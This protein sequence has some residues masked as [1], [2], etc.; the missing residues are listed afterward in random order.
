M[1]FDEM[2]SAPRTAGP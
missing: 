2:K 1:D